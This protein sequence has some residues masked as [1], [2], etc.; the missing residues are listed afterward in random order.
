MP[1][2]RATSNTAIPI[3]QNAKL[4]LSLAQNLIKDSI[5]NKMTGV[6]FHFSRCFHTLPRLRVTS[7]SLPG[8]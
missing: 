2:K 1:N 3:G 8:F 7:P 6:P 4:K 5:I